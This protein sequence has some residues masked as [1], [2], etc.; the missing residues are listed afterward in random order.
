MT[1]IE[2]ILEPGEKILVEGHLH[3]LAFVPSVV[4]MLVS[5]VIAA[6]LYALGAQFALVWGI[7][8]AIA[9]LFGL[10]HFLVKRATEFVVTDRRVILKTG[11]ITRHTLEMNNA[12]IESVDV[13][14][15]LLGRLFNYGTVEVRGTGS[16]IEPF[17]LVYD[18]LAFRRAILSM[19]NS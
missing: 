14:Q 18:P 15:T 7:V 17:K 12:K 16:A 8:L 3:W 5:V 6:V 9:F 11:F 10:V 19:S 1:Y 2:R 13:D 4:L